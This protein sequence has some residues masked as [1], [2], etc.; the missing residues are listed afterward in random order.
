MPV[1]VNAC[2]RIHSGRVF[3]IYQEDVT[4]ENGAHVAMEIIRHPGAAAIVALTANK[5]IL[6][7]RQYRHAVD[8]FIWE[9]PAGTISGSE[10]PLECARRELTEETGY[11]A[12][13]WSDLGVITP[14]PGYAD[15]RIHLFIARDLKEKAQ[16]L[17]QDEVITVHK[18]APEEVLSMVAGG[19]IQDAKTLS[20]LF[21]AQ[22]ANAI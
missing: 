16:N 3:D 7:I 18:V 6:L 12:D 22:T 19:K 8:G 11:C 15:E 13:T 4:L 2:Q 21:L 9:I 17:D 10:T 5:E 20:A 14:A 1:N